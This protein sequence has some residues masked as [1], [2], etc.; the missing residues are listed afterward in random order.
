MT[1]THR[2]PD[3]WV[4]QIVDDGW[5]DNREEW[6]NMGGQSL[7]VDISIGAFRCTQCGEVGY[8]TGSWRE[9]HENGTP[10]TG[11]EGVS[12]TREAVVQARAAIARAEGKA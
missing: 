11:S 1:C 8:Y 5:G 12:R 2:K 6:V 4:P 7:Q 3:R 9:F 10:C